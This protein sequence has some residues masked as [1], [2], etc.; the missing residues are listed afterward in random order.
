LLLSAVLR[1]SP[2]APLLLGTQRPPLSVDI[3]CPH[4]DQQ[5]TRRTPRLQSNNG[6]DRRT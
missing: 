3:S 6:T 1:L 2:A 5:Q 4:G